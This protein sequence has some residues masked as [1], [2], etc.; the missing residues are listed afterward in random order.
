MRA[1]VLTFRR[2]ASVALPALETLLGHEFLPANVA[3]EG[4]ACMTAS[5][6]LTS[7]VSGGLLA[8]SVPSPNQP[9]ASQSRGSSPLVSRAFRNVD[10][11]Q[12]VQ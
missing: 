6:G 9:Q 3:V 7:V 1:S 10:R 2:S 12:I 11:I 5:T 8:V 4:S